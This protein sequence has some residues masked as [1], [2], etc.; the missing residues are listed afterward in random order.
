MKKLI[1]P[2]VCILAL[3]TSVVYAGGGVSRL[4]FERSSPIVKRGIPIKPNLFITHPSR[5]NGTLKHT[6]GS[7][8]TRPMP[9][10][11]S[12]EKM[13]VKVR[14]LDERHER[15][16]PNTSS[17]IWGFRMSNPLHTSP[18]IQRRSF[19]TKLRTKGYEPKE[20]PVVSEVHTLHLPKRLEYL[21]ESYEVFRTPKDFEKMLE[22]SMHHPHKKTSSF[23]KEEKKK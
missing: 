6:Q 4:A 19:S 5:K 17:K 13:P 1:L 23:T 20:P 3:S 11:S 18:N 22:E 14:F 21:D 9:E 10:K 16:V 15:F 12:Y 7:K 2:S 8:P